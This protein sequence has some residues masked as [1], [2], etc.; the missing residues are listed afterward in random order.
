VNIDLQQ[1]LVNGPR[2]SAGILNAD[3][4]Q[5][6]NELKALDEVGI[7]L[8]HVD[9]MDGVFCPMLTVGPSIVKA[10]PE[11]FVKDVHLMIDEP[12]SKVEAFL[13]SGAGILTFHLEATKHPH[14]V[15][16]H[17]AGSRVLRGLALNPGTPIAASE[18]LLDH[19]ELLM[20]LAVNPGWVG[21]TFIDA[22]EQRIHEA[23]ALIDGRS[24]ALAVDGGVTRDNARRVA[25]LGVDLIVAGSAVFD[26]DVRVNGEFMRSAIAQ[27]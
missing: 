19:L 8:V 23:R 20:L 22:T 14:R 25:S 15:L 1:L 5:L 9:V 6:G 21:Q 2:L 16:Q 11:D 4:L 18:P 12:L 24:I 27:P 7:D 26:G 3:L 13:D 10:I 17:L